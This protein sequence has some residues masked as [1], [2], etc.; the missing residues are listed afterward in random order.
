MDPRREVAETIAKVSAVHPGWDTYEKRRAEDANEL[1]ASPKPSKWAFEEVLSWLR[2]YVEPGYPVIFKGDASSYIMEHL[3]VYLQRPEGEAGIY[4]LREEMLGNGSS[5]LTHAG[6]DEGVKVMVNEGS[7][8]IALSFD[9]YKRNSDGTWNLRAG[10]RREEQAF[11]QFV[12]DVRA[13][14]D[15]VF[16]F[17]A[18]SDNKTRRSLVEGRELLATSLTPADILYSA[19]NRGIT[20]PPMVVEKALPGQRGLLVRTNLTK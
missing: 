1:V 15:P 6:E 3:V 5:I 11:E 13:S 20:M 12:D 14:K 17:V 19:R 8:C 4:D 16:Y 2:D 18:G 10:A 9:C 7:E